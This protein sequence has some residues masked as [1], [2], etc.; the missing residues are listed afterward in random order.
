MLLYLRLQRSGEL[1]HATVLVDTTASD[2]VATVVAV[3]D[4]DDVAMDD[5]YCGTAWETLANE[6]R[7]V[8]TAMAKE[9]I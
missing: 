9:C 6:S 5:P 4:R 7:A 8:V 3:E 2:A 1:L